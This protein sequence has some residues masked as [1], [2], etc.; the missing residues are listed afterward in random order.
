MKNHTIVHVLLF[1][2]LMLVY[3][4]VGA[5]DFLITSKGDSLTGEVKPLFYGPEKKVQIHSADNEKTSFSLFQVR[6]FSSDGEIY[7]PVKGDNGY[8]FMKLI[9]GGYLSLYAYQLENQTRF[10]GL[11][12]SKLDG[13]SM[14]VPNL[15]FKKYLGGF[16]DDCPD[17]AARIKE[18]EFSKK[19]LTEIVDA[20]NACIESRTVDHDKAMAEG[21][22]RTT[23]INAWES[24]E[25][26]IREKEFDEKIDALEMIAEIRKKIELRE[27][28]PNFLIEGLKNSLRDKSLDADLQQALSQIN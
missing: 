16:L 15:G 23:K 14:S 7:H 3:Q 19:N 21:I 10:D 2:L 5:Q 22:E 18:G 11:F 17:V 12:L 28:I 9:Q 25:Q 26:K 8:V 20:Y 27:K 1:L 4:C 6:A 13:E 24:L